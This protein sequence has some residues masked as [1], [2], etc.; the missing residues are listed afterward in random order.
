M[1]ILCTEIENRIMSK[2]TVAIGN[3]Y[4]HI[5]DIPQSYTQAR[6][7]LRYQINKG[8]EKIMYFSDIGIK[9]IPNYLYLKA[10]LNTLKEAIANRNSI[11]VEFIISELID[12]IKNVNTSYF[13]AVCLYYD[14]INIFIKEI[15]EMKS[16]AAEILKK[17]Q[18][19]FLENF[20]YPI[21]NLI[22][23]LLSLSREVMIVIGDDNSSGTVTTHENILKYI[24][25]NYREK[26]F[27]V[28]MVADHFKLSFSNLSHQ[29][30]SY[31]GR[32]ISTFISSLKLAYAK[33]MLSTTNLPV[34]KI[35]ENLGYFQTSSFIRKF[36]QAGGITPKEYRNSQI[37]KPPHPVQA[38]KN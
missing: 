32:N 17:Q 33:E 26:D 18:M 8:T 30:K 24:E 38:E 29:F 20:D 6:T 5:T 25:T 16:S 4:N 11:K 27:C 7:V 12:T 2:I 23:I 34:S 10:E 19:L 35:A 31:T 36:R 15:Y 3:S 37:R 21:E 22:A 9:E 28:Q 14:V 13:F 1:E